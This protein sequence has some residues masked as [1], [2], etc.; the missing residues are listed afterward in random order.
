MDMRFSISIILMVLST[1]SWADGIVVDKVYHPYVIANEHELE[2]RLSSAQTDVSNRLAQQF[3]YGYS[4]LEN[5][6]LEGYIIA[7]RDPTGDFNISGYELEVRWILTEQGQYWADWGALFEIEARD[8]S[9]RYEAT[10]GILFEKEFVRTSLT[11]NAL[12]HYEFGGGRDETEAEF[13]LKYRYR[14]MPAFQPA[15]E[16]YAGKEFVG[17]GPAMMGVYRFDGQKQLK[18]EAGFIAEITQAGKDHTFRMAIEYEF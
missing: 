12:A 9:D 15:I 6:A 14:F 7:E 2:W 17:I 13:R 1:L 4:V 8:D 16:L 18:W 5:V 3:G 11:L 10:A